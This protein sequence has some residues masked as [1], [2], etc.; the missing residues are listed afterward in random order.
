MNQNKTPDWLVEIQNKSWEPEIL[1]SG[2]TLTFLFILSDY[3]YNFYGML[4]QDFAVFEV[5]ARVLYRVSIGILTGF[6]IILIIHLILRGFWTGLIGLSY[7]YP[8]GVNKK[9]LSE[10]NKYIDFASPETY[11]IK[12]EKIC[13][14]LFSIIFTSIVFV[15]GFFILFIPIILLFLIGLDIKYISII[16]LYVVVPLTFII[17]IL[18]S[19]FAKKIKNSIV[20][21]ALENSIFNYML[22]VFLTNIGKIKTTLIFVIIFIIALSISFSDMS[23]FNF[24]NRQTVDNFSTAGMVSLKKDHYESL[25]DHELRI[26]KATINQFQ[27]QGT[28]IQL[29]ISYFKE[30][31]YTI[32]KYDTN[33][34]VFKKFNVDTSIIKM[35]M[36]DIY[37]IRINDQKI[38]D[39]RWYIIENEYTNQRGLVA[40]IPLD[41]V[42]NG[43]HTLKIN[44]LYWNIRTGEV[45]LLENWEIIPFEKIERYSCNYK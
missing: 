43:F 29:F 38:K 4:V 33:P 30:D 34:E 3:I 22:S 24:K 31:V 36:S 5:I 1:I 26:P 42:Q 14:L 23:R 16:T 12:F 21:K 8:N 41:S 45:Q 7:V 11:V 6:K 10:K 44:K 20:Y 18:A 35:K 17:P 27:I 28:S 32:K 39:L 13:S 9:N 2:F 40:E 37:K 15:L 19:I 25:R